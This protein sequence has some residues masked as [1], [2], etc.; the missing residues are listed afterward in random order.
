MN[1]YGNIIELFGLP[2]SGKSTLA[3]LVA[4]E[5][6]GEG[7][8]YDNCLFRFMG[9]PKLIKAI[10]K[11]Y[12]MVKQL[13]INPGRFFRQLK[14]IVDTQQNSFKD[15][16]RLIVEYFF[17][18]NLI[19]EARQRNKKIILDEGIYHFLWS[20]C[21]DSQNCLDIESFLA[22]SDKSDFIIVLSIDDETMCQR[23]LSRNYNNRRLDRYVST[24]NIT[25][26]RKSNDIFDA[27]SVYLNTANISKIFIDNSIASEKEQ[28]SILIKNIITNLEQ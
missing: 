8:H 13:T 21:L 4:S 28:N 2:G 19:R 12:A 15:L 10:F 22:L 23:L 18:M 25:M 26:I 20:V 24:N 3:A 5:L 14:M 6:D 17:L 7:I 1:K 11:I 16:I 27:I 9:R